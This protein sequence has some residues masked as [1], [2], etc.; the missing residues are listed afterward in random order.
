MSSRKKVSKPSSSEKTA[1]RQSENKDEERETMEEEV[2]EREGGEGG[3]GGLREFVKK[4][5]G[6]SHRMV[7]MRLGVVGACAVAFRIL[8]Y[9]DLQD[10]EEVAWSVLSLIA[11]I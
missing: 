3:G 9:D 7:E 4:M 5:D 10:K 8:L 11:G 1:T 2:V 6:K